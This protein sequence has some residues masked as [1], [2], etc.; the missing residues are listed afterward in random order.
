MLDL[1]TSK[2]TA[3]VRL[4]RVVVPGFRYHITQRGVSLIPG[5]LGPK[6]KVATDDTLT[7]DPPD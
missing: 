6:S 2:Q 5:K 1:D 4:T 7:I 3:R